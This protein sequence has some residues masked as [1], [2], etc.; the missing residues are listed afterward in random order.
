MRIAIKLL[1]NAFLIGF[2]L[3]DALF[4]LVLMRADRSRRFELMTSKSHHF[5]Q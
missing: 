4:V 2:Q 3:I 5:S 1:N